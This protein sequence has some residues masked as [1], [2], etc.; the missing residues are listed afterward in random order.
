MPDIFLY[1]GAANPH[2]IIL[3]DPATS[4]GAITGNAAL[5]NGASTLA[6]NGT[7]LVTGNAA[8]TNAPSTLVANGTTGGGPGPVPVP[9]GESAFGGGSYED[10]FRR[11]VDEP[12]P[13]INLNELRLQREEE[14]I[15]I[16]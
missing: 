3:R 14:E 5:T 4:G 12:I 16:L 9:G 7:V 2:D 8:L 15:L 13:V 1:P 6:A 11:R 10:L